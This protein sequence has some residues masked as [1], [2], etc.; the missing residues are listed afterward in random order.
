MLKS[1]AL[2]TIAALL[3][4]VIGSA[5]LFAPAEVGSVIAPQAAP[6]I[7]QLLGAALLGLGAANWIGRFSAV[8][9]IYGRSLV[10]GNLVTFGIA[11][12]IAFRAALNQQTAAVAIVS[13][14]SLVLAACFAFVM[15]RGGTPR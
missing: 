1:N 12:L 14:V 8:G 2:V 4:F 11:G 15:L 10:V 5:L 6:L 7:S 9:G 3:L 13:F